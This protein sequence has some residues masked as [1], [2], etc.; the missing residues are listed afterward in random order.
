MKPAGAWGVTRDTGFHPVFLAPG[1]SKGGCGTEGK[2]L[3]V[4]QPGLAVAP[5]P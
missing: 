5:L 2:V 4:G 1:K 3:Q